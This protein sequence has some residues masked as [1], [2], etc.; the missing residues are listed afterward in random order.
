MNIFVNAY[1]T[2]KGKGVTMTKR[3]VNILYFLLLVLG[4]NTEVAADIQVDQNAASINKPSIDVTPNGIDMV[5]IV[6]PSAAGVSHNKFTQFDVPNEGVILNNSTSIGTSQLSGILPGNPKL[7][8]KPATIILNEVTST[9]ASKLLGVTEIFGQQA[10][11]VLANPNGITCNGCG[12]INTP[13]VTI[14]TGMPTI[15][16]ESLGKVK[17][18][19]GKITIKGD[20]MQSDTSSRLDLISRAIMLDGELRAD[21]GINIITGNNTVDYKT[22][23]TAALQDTGSD[24]PLTAIDITEHGTIFAGNI[25]LLATEKGLGVNSDGAIVTNKNNIIITANGDLKVNQIIASAKS[26]TLNAN[27]ISVNDTSIL[28]GVALTD[29]NIETKEEGDVTINATSNVTINNAQIAAGYNTTINSAAN[30]INNNG[31]IAAKKDLNIISDKNIT[32]N[33]GDIVAFE[34]DITV[35]NTPANIDAKLSNISG[36]IISHLGNITIIA[37]DIEQKRS[38]MKEEVYIGATT[39]G[40]GTKHIVQTH[41]YRIQGEASNP[42]VLSANQD[43]T[44]NAKNI[45]ND[46]SNINA[47]NNITILATDSLINRSQILQDWNQVF[48]MWRQGGWRS[49]WNSPTVL[50]TET[51]PA[52]IHATGELHGDITGQINNT[53]I[54]GKQI[55]ARESIPI[56]NFNTEITMPE[57]D[58]A[59]YKINNTPAALYKVE[60]RTPFVNMSNFIN[61][62]YLLNRLGF[63]P[64]EE[65]RKLLGDP[66]YE[67]QFIQQQLFSQNAHNI[68]KYN[69]NI[70]KNTIKSLFENAINQ[71]KKLQLSVGIALSAKQ[72][73]ALTNDIIWLVEHT[74]DGDSVLVPTVY[75]AQHNYIQHPTK[76]SVISAQDVSLKTNTLKNSGTI[77]SDSDIT[78]EST[79]DINNEGGDIITSENI[80]L[81]S[82]K[83]SIKHKAKSIIHH[84]ANDIQSWITSA[85]NVISGGKTEF[86]AAKN[87]ELAGAKIFSSNNTSLIAENDISIKSH[88]IHNRQEVRGKN[89]QST[90]ETVTHEH[91]NISSKGEINLLAGNNYHQQGSYISA[92][93]SINIGAG[94]SIKIA[95]VSDK[96]YYSEYQKK[97]GLTKQSIYRHQSLTNS[98]RPSL[99]ESNNNIKIHSGSHTSQLAS[100]LLAAGNIN[101]AAGNYQDNSG[102]L[103]NNENASVHIV[104]QNNSHISQTVQT[105]QKRKLGFSSGSISLAELQKATDSS[106]SITTAP[107]SLSAGGDITVAAN[108]D[109]NLQGSTI[110]SANNVTLAANNN[111]MLISNIEQQQKYTQ[112]SNAKLSVGLLADTTEIGI[113]ARAELE[114]NSKTETAKTHQPSTVK[115]KNTT[116]TSGNSIAILASIIDSQN[117]TELSADNNIT[118]L[119]GKNSFTSQQNSKKAE[120]GAKLSLSQN[121]TNA[122]KAI[123]NLT[124]INPIKAV[125]DS[126]A[127]VKNGFNLDNNREGVK[128]T[129]TAID[130][131]L[132][133]YGTILNPIGFG[134]G[135]YA[136]IEEN[137]SNQQHNTQTASH[138]YAQSALT[139]NAGN[140]TS[141][142]SSN[143]T[144]GGSISINTGNTLIIESLQNSR[145]TNSSDTKAELSVI[146]DNNPSFS[147][148]RGNTKINSYDTNV[149]ANITG[150]NTVI[151]TGNNTHIKGAVIEGIETLNLVSPVITA[152][153]IHNNSSFKTSSIGIDKT[154]SKYG[155]KIP[156]INASYSDQEIE[157]TTHATISNGNI[158]TNSDI[159]HINRDTSKITST[160]HTTSFSSKITLPEHVLN[161]PQL[162]FFNVKTMASDPVEIINSIFD[163]A[164]REGKNIKEFADTLVETLATPK[165][166]KPEIKIITTEDPSISIIE[167]TTIDENGNIEVI[168]QKFENTVVQACA[169]APAPCAAV[170]Q[171]VADSILVAMGT[172]ILKEKFSD[173]KTAN[174]NTVP[175]QQSEENPDPEEEPENTLTKWLDSIE[176][177]N[178]VQDTIENIFTDE[179]ETYIDLTE[180]YGLLEIE[181]FHSR[182]EITRKWAL[183]NVKSNYLNREEILSSEKVEVIKDFKTNSYDI[184]HYLNK[185]ILTDD[186]VVLKNKIKILDNIIS[187]NEISK[188]VILYHAFVTDQKIPHEIN[189]S[190]KRKQYISSSL[191]LNEAM[192]AVKG[193]LGSDIENRKIYLMK[194]KVPSGSKGYY[195]DKDVDQEWGESEIILPRNSTFKVLDVEKNNNDLSINITTKLI[196]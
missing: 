167:I 130:S 23:N 76:A 90:K 181:R 29:S 195:I 138:I 158:Q 123:T 27:K 177:V 74:K 145:N 7:N 20:G 170:G 171:L 114:Q 83:G 155:G 79:G 185:D 71:Q 96:H 81:T 146:K 21:K 174:K 39:A 115:A 75:Y 98:H 52:T 17:V 135:L 139:T 93:G 45:V 6:A 192:A 119:S 156:S 183:K 59:L 133:I 32:N 127:F 91:S 57:E 132:T 10:E 73:A 109:I 1:P 152:E 55:A 99:I 102:V 95:S 63:D 150:I 97:K 4:C 110:E 188:N 126:I 53:T 41:H 142:K 60:T 186:A 176:L 15:T 182:D 42:A 189:K 67:S 92:E 8:Q 14:T 33:E 137:K 89:F 163:K 136:N 103:H 5:N 108:K 54:A 118:V 113:K 131:V 125:S 191:D 44:I 31:V 88:A 117:K 72:I 37:D 116:L 49:R 51:I 12:F 56:K 34:G 165:T 187:K 26:T 178:Q 13:R 40:T 175:S 122:F 180:E 151:N 161:D 2:L 128:D 22:L 147:I 18:D 149:I 193:Y 121:I 196:K 36:N 159:S 100:H 69:N 80:V 106:I 70:L 124:N 19:S 43:I 173:N 101:V 134:A 25:K 86:A 168:S 160:N 169:V 104:S 84:V 157:T 77:E 140:N 105:K 64:I 47:G 144:S 164:V 120:I 61:S 154:L 66:Y 112:Q 162:A 78:I 107:S 166:G 190:F 94:D 9:H 65:N 179:E 85:A 35:T 143:L 172:T 184:N 111:I 46:A 11:Y 48:E 58:T 3:F 38:H 141:I 30:V 87:I 68:L 148:A 153:N 16:A 194:I 82:V 62:E 129:A 28:A 24:K 50:R